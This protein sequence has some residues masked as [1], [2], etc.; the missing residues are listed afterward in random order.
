MITI[1]KVG[2]QLHSISV[3]S[4]SNGQDTTISSAKGISIDEA[5]SKILTSARM[6]EAGSS[7][8]ILNKPGNVGIVID[9]KS[10]KLAKVLEKLEKHG[11]E[12]LDNGEYKYK[13]IFNNSVI[14]IKELF[15]KQFGQMSQDSDQIG[16]QP[17]NSKE[18]INKWLVA[19]LKSATGDLNH[20]GMLTKIKALSVFGT[21]VWQLMNPPEGN[22]GSVSQKAKQYSM[23]VEQNK[24]TL[25]EFVLS[26]I[27]SFSSAT[28]GKETFSH[29]FS[30]FSAKTRTKTFDD[31]LTRARSERMPMVEND[32]G[33]YEVVNG[34]YEDANTYGLGFGQ[35]IQKVHEGNPQQQLKLDAALNGNKNINGIKREN[36]PI[37]DLNRP[38][39]MSEDEMKS[40]PN[41]YQSLGLDKEIKKHY[42]NH[43]TGINRWQPFG[44]YAADSASRGV[45]FAGAQ[46]GGTCDILLASTLLSGKSLYSNENDVI[47][48]TIGIAAFMNYGGYH[49]FNEVI[50]IGEAMSKNKPFVPSNRTE[51]NRADLYE[52][53]QGHAKK[54]LPPQTEQGITKYHLAH[55]DIVAEVKRQHP[56]VSLELTNE[57]ILF[58]KVGS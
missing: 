35:V 50:P 36:A 28:L 32:R 44:M 34:E 23:S 39:M 7:I 18:S 37:Q 21:T 57:D 4:L 1:N 12:K 8:N 51:S 2:N 16:R 48:L 6:F 13:V 58:N 52:R 19:Q 30:E 5:K 56:S 54:F 49:T 26:D 31:P 53:V 27:C 22:N 38:Y 40:I 47:P 14:S 20:S 15:D 41:S 29:L 33:G 55:S 25:A 11:G 43:G 24:A 45:P 17:L 9:D 3:E 42:L 46:S 10:K